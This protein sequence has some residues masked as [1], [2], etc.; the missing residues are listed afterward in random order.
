MS[1]QEIRDAINRGAD[2]YVRVQ[3]TPSLTKRVGPVEVVSVSRAAVRVK[4]DGKRER[5]VPFTELEIDAPQP[6]KHE[7]KHEAP[8]R[9]HVV[10]SPRTPVLTEIPRAA[11]KPAALRDPEPEPPLPPADPAS[12]LDAWL[13]MGREVAQEIIQRIAE[14]MQERKALHAEAS[15]IAA[16][17]RE[18]EAELADFTAKRDLIAKLGRDIPREPSR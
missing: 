15:A 14:L 12:S 8:P 3:V 18:V 2:V 6:K 9:I 10:P 16:R 5:M 13:E 17:D 1:A 11:D 7:T 4:V